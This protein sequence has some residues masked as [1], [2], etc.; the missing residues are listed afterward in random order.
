MMVALAYFPI[1][2][3]ST[4]ALIE[5]LR[6]LSDGRVAR[7]V[8]GALTFILFLG[9]LSGALTIAVRLL[10]CRRLQVPWVGILW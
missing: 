4:A 5:L 7:A 6:F 8:N 3:W 2:L 1:A 9:A 10:V